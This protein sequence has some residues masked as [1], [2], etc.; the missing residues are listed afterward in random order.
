MFQDAAVRPLGKCA[1][2]DSTF[3]VSACWI[4]HIPH[5]WMVGSSRYGTHKLH[6]PRGRTHIVSGFSSITPRWDVSP[7]PRQST[8]RSEHQ[9]GLLLRATTVHFPY[10]HLQQTAYS[11]NCTIRSLMLVHI[12]VKNR[13]H[14]QEAA[15]IVDTRSLWAVNGELYIRYRSKINYKLIKYN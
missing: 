4:N 3:Q 13:S 9:R 11:I 8:H 6:Y 5:T 14:L 7:V 12:S 1:W 2:P 10:I 15:I